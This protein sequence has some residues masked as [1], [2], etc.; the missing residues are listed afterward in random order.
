[1]DVGRGF[2][3]DP[4]QMECQITKSAD[5]K[6]GTGADAYMVADADAGKA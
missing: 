2:G 5:A 3:A 6:S 4:I 1:M